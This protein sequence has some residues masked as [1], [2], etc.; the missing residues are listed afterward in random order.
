MGDRS[1]NRSVDRTAWIDVEWMDD[2]VVVHV[3]GELDASVAGLLRQAV[4]TSTPFSSLIIDLGEV[5][6]MDSSGLGAVI[7]GLRHVREGGGRAGIAR[8]RRS[9]RHLLE[10]SGVDRLVPIGAT[11]DAVVAAFVEEA[12]SQ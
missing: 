11:P 10:M 7:S 4:V 12:A 1:V 6:F 3:G 8:P 5:P 2:C 9:I